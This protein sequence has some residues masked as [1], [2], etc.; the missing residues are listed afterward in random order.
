MERDQMRWVLDADVQIHELKL[1]IL[2]MAQPESYVVKMDETQ[3]MAQLFRFLCPVTS[4]NTFW[5]FRKFFCLYDVATVAVEVWM[6]DDAVALHV[7]DNFRS[8]SWEQFQVVNLLE[9]SS[10]SSW[11]RRQ[12]RWVGCR[13][14]TW[15]SDLLLLWTIIF[16]TTT[17]TIHRT[18]QRSWARLIQI[19]LAVTCQ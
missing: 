6:L 19:M 13:A 18:S 17:T 9:L 3:F 15:H 16:R 7:L 8:W 2:F 10:R 5:R 11:H 1:G 14:K 4:G 12:C